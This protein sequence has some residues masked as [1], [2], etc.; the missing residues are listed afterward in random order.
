VLALWSKR[1]P[2]ASGPE[3]TT[4]PLSRREAILH[5]L[6][7]GAERSRALARPCRRRSAP[8]L[9]QDGVEHLHD[10]LLLGARQLLDALD[11]LLKLGCRSA[12]FSRRCGVAQEFLDRYPERSCEHGERGDGDAAVPHLVGRLY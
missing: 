3:A 2:N 11:L 8:G 1:D 7:N 4:W 12:L 5:H 10:E 9:L 6:E